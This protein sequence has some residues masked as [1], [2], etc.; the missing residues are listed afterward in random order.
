MVI[1]NV[2]ILCQV[3]HNSNSN[4]KLADG[5]KTQS[6]SSTILSDAFSI[7]G[8]AGLYGEL[9]SS[10]KKEGRRKPSTGRLFFRP[11]I[12]LFKN[13]NIAF[14]ILLS[15]EGSYTR[16]QLNRISLHPSWSWGK[17]HIGD[18]THK[19]SQYSLNDVTITGGGLE[20]NYGIVRFEA[21]GGRT[22]RK[23]NA[24]VSNSA[25]ARYLGG[26][27]LGVG[28][29]G[30]SFIDLN[31]IRVKDDI[32]SLPSQN[33]IGSSS[34]ITQFRITPTENIVA[35]LNGRIDIVNTVQVY[36]EFSGSVLSRD[37][38]S[39]EVESEEIPNF[40]NDV[41]TIRHSTFVDY[42]YTT[43]MDFK[44]DAYNV[45][46]EYSVIN[47]G[48][49]SLGLSTNL[50]DR[51]TISFNAGARFLKN[52]LILRGNYRLN[53]NNLLSQKQNT[54]SRANYGLQAQ[55][56]PTKGISFTVRAS[57]NTMKNDS[58]KFERRINNLSSVYTFNGVWRLKL[59]DLNHT[60]TGSYSNQLS[61][62]YNY[63]MKNNDSYT[64]NYVL[65]IS[66]ILDKNWTISPRISIN[67]FNQK[68]LI[69]WTTSNFGLMVSN[70]M[71]SGK[72]NN[73][74]GLSYMNSRFVK[75]PSL[76]IQSNYSITSSDVIKLNLRSGFYWGKQSFYVNFNEY[77]GNL[78][79]T[80]RF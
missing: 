79:Y 42:A 63:T 54:L 28:K 44:Y 19:F 53:K 9:Y 24:G 62:N 34:S 38:Y 22:Q 36:G 49:T 47:P 32:N 2:S 27:K 21:V 7:S 48:Y 3:D 30:G 46:A 52:K 16:Q 58:Y 77:R 11:T 26:F 37:L 43:G 55:L 29:V 74:F 68:S 15:S 71:L 41:F 5:L 59:F 10:S 75:S 33:N 45:K 72:L 40:V 57:F 61:K 12:T 13:F 67:T 39:E 23:I 6:N 51:R 56:T 20:L 14:D 1:L 78:T 65:G 18:F 50:N 8:Q 66:T 80:H 64:N 70:R 25:Y 35:A 60:I 76:N 73:S 4:L 17:A 69:L 31:I